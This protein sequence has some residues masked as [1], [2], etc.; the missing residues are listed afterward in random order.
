MANPITTIPLKGGTRYGD[1]SGTLQGF[2]V[3]GSQVIN[4]SFFNDILY[5]DAHTLIDWARGGN[6]TIFAGGGNDRS[7]AMPITCTNTP[8][9]ETTISMAAVAAIPSSATA[10][11][12]TKPPWAGTT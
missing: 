5:G 3:G 12:C 10:C 6:D 11:S 8:A 2:S 1:T 9:A 7:L 4:G